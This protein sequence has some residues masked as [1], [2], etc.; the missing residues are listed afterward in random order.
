MATPDYRQDAVLA[1]VAENAGTPVRA[2]DVAA[3]LGITP[4]SACTALS[5]LLKRQRLHIAAWHRNLGGG[6]RPA[7]MYAHGP[8][9][10]APRPDPLPR[11]V[12]T[13]KGERPR[14]VVRLPSRPATWLSVLSA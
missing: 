12:P 6:G 1:I 11:Y 4:D 10:D 14:A 5:R 9:D 2:V 13:G 8:G 3:A 7:P